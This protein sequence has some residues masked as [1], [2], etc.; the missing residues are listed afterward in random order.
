VNALAQLSSVLYDQGKL[1]EAEKFGREALEAGRRGPGESAD[2]TLAAMNEVAIIDIDLGKYDESEAFYKRVLEVQAAKG[3]KD[4]PYYMQTL[5]NLAQLY[6]AQDRL[7]EAET[8][9]TEALERHRRV[10]GNEHNL[11]LTAINNLAI[12]ERRLKH[13]DKA[14]PL[15]QESYET[16]RRTLGDDGLPTLLPMMNLARFYAATG[17]CRDQRA[18]ID[19]AVAQMRQHAPPDSPL[20]ATAFRVDGECRMARGDLAGAEAPLIESEARVSK[21]FPGDQTRLGELR[22]EIAD[23]YERLGRPAKAAEWHARAAPPEGPAAP[24]SASGPAPAPGPAPVR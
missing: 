20:I 1:E 12:I 10:L 2:E 18:F 24:A 13:Y 11:T 9:A 17:R 8:M 23:L 19:R 5:G 16:A 21:L 15:Y 4:S 14:E 22:T 7:E 3:G 6:V